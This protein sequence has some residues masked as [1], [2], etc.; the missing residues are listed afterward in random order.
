MRV[1]MRLGKGVDGDGGVNK[2]GIEWEPS[3]SRS[4]GLDG[5]VIRT[6]HIMRRR[7]NV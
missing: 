5:K 4:E 6:G 7:E 3:T 1:W 2:F